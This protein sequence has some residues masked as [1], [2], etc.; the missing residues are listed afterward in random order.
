MPKK[1]KNINTRYIEQAP[2]LS[3][4]QKTLYFSSNRQNEFNYDIYKSERKDNSWDHWSPPELLNDTVNTKSWES[5][6]KT[7]K[8]GSMAYFSTN[9][10]YGNRSDIYSL[11]I[12][13]EKPF[14]MVAGQVIN[15]KNNLPVSQEVVY[16]ILANGNPV[17]S[18]IFNHKNAT[19]RLFLPLGNSYSLVAKADQ[20]KSVNYIV[21]ASEWKEYTEVNQNLLM[22]PMDYVTLQ[23]SMLIRSTGKKIPTEAAPKIRINDIYSTQVML[24]AEDGT[25]SVDLPL[26]NK[27]TLEVYTTKYESEAEIIDLTNV[28]TFQTIRQNLY[29]DEQ[30]TAII[31]GKIFDKKT[32]KIIPGDIP[33]MLNIDE[34]TISEVKIDEYDRTYSLE[35]ALGNKY[36]ISAVAE[37]YYPVIENIDLRRENEKIKIMKDLYL[38]P[39]EIGQSVRLDNIFFE[40]A[41]SE[42]KQE[43]F[44]ELQ[45]VVKLLNDH[46]SI[47]I[48][49][50]GHTDNV[51]A[52]EYNLDLSS[53]RAESVANYLL[54]QGIELSRITFKGYGLTKPV[55]DNNTE[56]GRQINRRVEFTI[57]DK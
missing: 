55:A 18:M 57:I 8:L 30:K 39:I 1:I 40:T 21:D 32:D 46:N 11:K 45:R 20:F 52:A 50:G 33:L 6:Y 25:Y 49:I 10:K 28:K 14:V 5:F 47:R 34:S 31:T 16:Q 42:L 43:S 17:D 22:E 35:L 54:Q 37:N 23:G 3:T 19:F 29:V 51:G 4:D 12:F 15:N 26:G 48:E 53:R 13:E 44:E 56:L 38:V 9:S 2:F 7:N 24:N 36:E 27:Y 41:K